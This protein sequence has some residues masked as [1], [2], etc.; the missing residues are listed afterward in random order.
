MQ[1]ALLSDTR[2]PTN[3]NY[4]GHGLGR[5]IAR[6]AIGLT[7]RGHKV[8]VFGGK[9]SDVSGCTVH[10]HEDENARADDLFRQGKQYDAYVDC[11]HYFRLATLAPDWPILC[12]VVDMEGHAPRNRIY[13]CKRHALEHSEPDGQI[14]FEGLDI[15]DIPFNPGPRGDHL[16]WCGLKVAWKRPE[17][18]VEIAKKADMPIILMG[19]GSL[20]GLAPEL[21]AIAPPRYYK[22]IGRARG[23]VSAVLTMSFLEGAATGTPSLYL[24]EPG[25][26]F[27]EDGITGYS[28]PVVDDLAKLAREKMS[29]LDAGK[30]RA[31]VAAER[32]VDKM[33]ALWERALEGVIKQPD[34]KPKEV[35]HA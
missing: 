12:K 30:M 11:S 20:E 32:S 33:A 15:D 16:L 17:L 28:A 31:W 3:I 29:A 34:E 25:D 14:I 21:P 26:T 22:V 35:I 18:A 9:G 24:G 5:S 27:V 8:T 7:K 6:I 23:I 19:E 1:I 10:M 13:G 2:L 4:G